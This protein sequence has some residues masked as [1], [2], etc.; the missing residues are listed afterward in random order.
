M[1]NAAFLKQIL[2]LAV[3]NREKAERTTSGEEGGRLW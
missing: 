2:T 1:V 3:F